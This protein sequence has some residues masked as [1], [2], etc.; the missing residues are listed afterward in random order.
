M[1]FFGMNIVIRDSALKH[2]VSVYAINACLL[3]IHAEIILDADPEKRLF[4][5]FDHN[6]NPLEIIGVMEDETLV[7]I[8]AMKLRS[9]FYY[10]LEEQGYE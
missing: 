6:A 1:L 3:H 5:G 4:V 10:L 9:Q 7:V 8:H 2:G